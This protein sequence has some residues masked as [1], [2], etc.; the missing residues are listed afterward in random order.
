MDLNYLYHRHG[1]SLAM[2]D[3][4]LCDRSR[5]THLRFAAAYAKDIATALRR[6]DELLA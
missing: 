3:R 5:N 2:A 6:N 4:A 1:F